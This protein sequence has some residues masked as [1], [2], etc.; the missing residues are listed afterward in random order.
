MSNS[1][2]ADLDQRIALAKLSLRGLAIGDGF[3]Q[4]FFGTP[5]TVASMLEA[6]AMPKPPWRWTDDTAMAISV[7]EVL[8][9][10]ARIDRDALARRF[11]K[12]YWAEPDRGY[13]QGAH[14]ILQAVNEGESWQRAAGSVFGGRGS[15]G[16]GAAMRVAPIGAFFWDDTAQVV[17]N[18]GASA[19]PTHTH[20]EGRVGAIAIALAAAYAVREREGRNEGQ[21]LF[22]F[23]LANTP[24]SETRQGIERAQKLSLEQEVQNAAEQL[25]NGSEISAQD[26][27]PLC[28][29]LLARHMDDFEE[30]MWNTVNALG[31]R[32]T[33]CAIVGGVVAL[34]VGE[35]GL[36][37]SFAEGCEALPLE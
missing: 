14:R 15:Y 22:D 13:G 11:A 21:G 24:A 18:A 10:H 4:R 32:D 12:R 5:A 6:R 26:T 29:W 9:D 37:D 19:D 28:I 33:T 3:G 2:A 25:G 34:R 8:R 35:S 31:D 1:E 27:V 17:D 16:N 30:A 23:V 7:Y 36:P 20:L